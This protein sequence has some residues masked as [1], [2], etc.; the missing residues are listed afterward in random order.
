MSGGKANDILTG[1]AG[2]DILKDT[3]GNN[4]LYGDAGH[5]WLRA[6]Q[7]DDEV[8]G[9]SGNDILIGR[10]GDDRLNGGTGDDL[11]TGGSGVD[12][13]YLSS[14]QDIIQ[15]FQDGRDLLG[16]PMTI[17]GTPLGFSDLDVVQV[18]QNTEIRSC[19]EGL[20][21]L[22][23]Q[24]HVTILQGIRASQITVNDFVQPTA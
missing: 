12:R 16:L 10:S 4:I 21:D 3:Q 23:S 19:K 2:D 1:G 9:D 8:H 7:G 18:G 13:F 15:D 24:M 22:G 11:L 17:N 14:G 5:D 6:G 20:G